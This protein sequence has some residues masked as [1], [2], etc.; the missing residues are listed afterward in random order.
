MRNLAHSYRRPLMLVT[1]LF[2]LM[3]SLELAAGA[4]PQAAS[5]TYCSEWNGFY[6]QWNIEELA[7]TSTIKEIRLVATL[8]NISSEPMSSVPIRLQPA[9]KF[10]LLVHDMP[11]FIPDSYGS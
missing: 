4:P 11:G 5:Q 6:G 9:G 3:S 2:S 10:D 8:Y 1:C 7:N